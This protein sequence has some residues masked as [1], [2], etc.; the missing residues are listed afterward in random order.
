[1]FYSFF[2]KILCSDEISPRLSE[3]LGKSRDFLRKIRK[4]FFEK[5]R[6]LVEILRSE[7]WQKY[8]HLCRSRQ[9][10][11]Q[12]VFTCKNRRRY[13]RERAFQI[14]GVR[15]VRY[16]PLPPPGSTGPM[17]TAQVLLVLITFIT[18]VLITD[19]IHSDV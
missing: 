17:R 8:V 1:M 6:T 9:E 4:R 18:A 3:H 19:I 14:L 15:G 7:R 16:R 5:R 2:N 10:L 13:S 11:S 12:R